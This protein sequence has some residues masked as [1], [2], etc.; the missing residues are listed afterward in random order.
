[1]LF[2]FLGLKMQIF[3]VYQP[4]LEATN[5]H[6]LGEIWTGK[7]NPYTGLFDGY[8]FGFCLVMERRGL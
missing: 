8:D 4:F 5:D 3:I 2:D 7:Q 1:M 6:M